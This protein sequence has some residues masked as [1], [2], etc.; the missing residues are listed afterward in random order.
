V[1]WLKVQAPVLKKEKNKEKEK[2]GTPP[3]EPQLQ[4]NL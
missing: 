2:A 4:S 1:E 3:L